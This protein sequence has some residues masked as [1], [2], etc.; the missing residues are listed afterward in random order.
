[1]QKLLCGINTESQYVFRQ[2]EQLVNMVN[3]LKRENFNLEQELKLWKK[4]A[5][6]F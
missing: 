1:M 5:N 4:A 3:R 2:M 6:I